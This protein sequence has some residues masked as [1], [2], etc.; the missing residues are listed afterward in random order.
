VQLN[1]LTGRIQLDFRSSESITIQ[2]VRQIEELVQAGA[3]KKGDQL[4]TVRELATEL[5]IN[6]S[7]VARAYKLL[8]EVRVI[9]TQRGRGTYIWDEPPPEAA[10]V[11][12]R[13]SLEEL[14]RTYLEEA[15]RLGYDAD[16]AIEALTR[17]IQ[18]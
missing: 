6:F 16:S 14:A 4:P 17:V 9:S 11:L 13:Q 10:Q 12:K 18:N 5:R 8:D 2:I 3:L 15:A 1:G 7:T